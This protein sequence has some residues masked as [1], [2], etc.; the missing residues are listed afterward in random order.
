MLSPRKQSVRKT[1]CS[2]LRDIV[3]SFFMEALCMLFVM[4]DGLSRLRGL[5]HLLSV[6]EHVILQSF[7]IDKKGKL[8]VALT[9]LSNI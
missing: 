3:P 6:N 2:Y 5:P 9:Y 1:L 7:N 8:L 4:E